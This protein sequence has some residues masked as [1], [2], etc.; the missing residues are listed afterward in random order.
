MYTTL[1]EKYTKLENDISTFYYNHFVLLWMPF[2]D[3]SA[4]F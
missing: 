2:S 3:L 1:G 4:E